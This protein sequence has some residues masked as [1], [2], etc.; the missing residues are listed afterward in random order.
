MDYALYGSLVLFTLAGGVTPGPN[1]II[2]MSMGLT[3]GFK[4]CLPYIA[5]VAVGFALLLTAAVLGLGAVLKALPA[6]LIAVTIIGALW[7]IW[8]AYGFAKAAFVSSKS[9]T[10]K[11]AKPVKQRPLGFFES[12][13]FQWV[14][15]KGLI[16][17]IGAAASYVGLHE[18]LWVRLAVIIVT[19]NLAGLLGN[20][21]WA[22]AGGS[23]NQLLSGGKWARLINGVMAAV[24]FAT[25]VFILKEGL[26]PQ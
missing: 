10:A 19:F 3:F 15:P 24:I 8:L 1:N 14:N 7:L 23:L 4:K 13:V 9:D 5:G 25:A 18:N 11:A 20:V 16:F 2:L 17:A 22:A 21:A 12:V 26:K 6:L